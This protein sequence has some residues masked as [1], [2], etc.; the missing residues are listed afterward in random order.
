MA[1]TFAHLLYTDSFSDGVLNLT[2][3]HGKQLL[4]QDGQAANI[5]Y[6]LFCGEGFIDNAFKSITMAFYLT[7]SDNP[8]KIN[9]TF[10][11]NFVICSAHL[12]QT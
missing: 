5:V 1:T 10:R 11:Q 12:P 3:R 7:A 2:T 4:H 6:T 9:A 8:K